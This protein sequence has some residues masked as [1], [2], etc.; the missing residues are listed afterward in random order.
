[1]SISNDETHSKS[2]TNKSHKIKFVSKHHNQPTWPIY[3]LFYNDILQWIVPT[4]VRTLFLRYAVVQSLL[5][6]SF[7]YCVYQLVRY[8]N[9]ISEP[10]IVLLTLELLLCNLAWTLHHR[11]VLYVRFNE[12]WWMDP[13]VTHVNRLDMHTSAIRYFDQEADARRA[14]CQPELAAT[15]NVVTLDALAW[16]FQLFTTVETALAAVS[17][18]DAIDMHVPS[19][20]MLQPGVDD[21]PIYTNMK[22]PFKCLP[23]ILPDENPTGVYQVQ[24]AVPWSLTTSAADDVSLVLQGVESAVYVNVNNKFI[25]FSKDSRLPCEFDVTSAITTSGTNTLRLVVVRWSDGSYVEDQDH[26]W[27]AGL[28]RS[29]ELLRRPRGADMT[30]Y[31]V[32][33]DASG[34]L[35]VNI[36][37]RTGNRQRKVLARLYN[38]RQVTADGDGWVQ[39]TCVWTSGDV[40]VNAG[41]AHVAISGN[42]DNAALWT[43]ETPNLYTLTISWLVDDVVKQVEFCRVGFRTVD[44]VEG[45]VRVN[46]KAIMI[47]GINRHEHDPDT[48]KV[49]SLTR[50][51]QDIISL[52]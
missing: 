14:A 12:C 47:C 52:K 25:G 8:N 26:W 3:D 31:Q 45:Q 39:G 21:I 35:S 48:G 50:M 49:V 32:Q 13:S 36:T 11:R 23:P 2:H 17:L 34:Q 46:G 20:W 1:M 30:D 16:K 4:H 10:W 28:H 9:N 18:E 33:A 24:F 22:Y 19:N 42:L 29:V 5:L 37:C 40:T 15:G 44:I 51:K 38:D 41:D 27:M 7:L 6:A 43:A